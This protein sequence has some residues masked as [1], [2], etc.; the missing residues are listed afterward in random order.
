MSWKIIWS[1]FAE[2][3]LDKI[4]DYY[5]ENASPQVAEKLLK[6][7]I[8]APQGLLRNPHIG[9]VEEQLKGLENEYRY[10]VYKSYKII[11]SLNHQS[12]QIKIADVF[13]T[14]QNP[15]KI[16]RKK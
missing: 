5:Q 15:G 11:F 12:K 3:Q 6:G 7:I 8:S 10:L 9:P 16:K 1:E 4:F 13:D 14:R 2:K